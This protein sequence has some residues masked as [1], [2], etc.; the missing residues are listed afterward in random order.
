ME[1]NISRVFPP[2]KKLEHFAEIFSALKLLGIN[3]V[4][5][6]KI[7]AKVDDLAV[8]LWIHDK[9]HTIVYGNSFFLNNVANCIQ[10]SCYQ[11]LM[12]R[13]KV[14]SCCM[15]QKCIAG[16]TTQRCT[17]CKRNYLGY[18]I[19]IVHAPVHNADG[20]RFVIKASYYLEESNDLA[21]RIEQKIA[22][23]E[24]IFLIMCSVCNRI[25][26]KSS[27]WVSINTIPVDSLNIRIS[28]GICPECTH[29]LYPGLLK[30]T[31]ADTPAKD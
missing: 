30:Q 1:A 21:K 7:I 22:D 20:D 19:N 26:D 14:C 28:H 11:R 17:L 18:D 29:T 25:K 10:Q 3:E 16:N 2:R 24:P 31:A 12:G 5:L 8:H 9:Q 27:S 23:N 15:S 4:A 6:D 13:K